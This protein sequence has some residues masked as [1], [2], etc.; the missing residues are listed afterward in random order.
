MSEAHK[1]IKLSEETKRKMSKSHKG[2]KVSKETRR[3]ISEANKG[4]KRTEEAKRKISEAS[5]GRPSPMQGK[6]LTKEHKLKLSLS[7]KGMR[8]SPKTEFKKG[9]KHIQYGLKGEKHHNWN[10]G[11]TI[12]KDY[13]FIYS[14]KH[15]YHKKNYVKE[16]RL[17]MEKYMGRYLSQ[18]EVVHHRDE[19]KK[20]N[21]IS[22]LFL[23]SDNKIHKKFHDFKLKNSS[24]FEEDFMQQIVMYKKEKR[25]K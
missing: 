17:V 4:K 22:N 6:K 13:V 18:K 12:I 23:F 16:H 9:K 19:N 7:H 11:R 8:N 24:L 10:G 2:H 21:H 20:N 25:K 14:P 1:G 5:K 3:K 15:H